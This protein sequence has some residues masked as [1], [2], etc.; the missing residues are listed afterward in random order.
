[1]KLTL[2]IKILIIALV[3]LLCILLLAYSVIGIIFLGPSKDASRMLVSTLMETSAAK[4]V[5]RLYMSKA[6][7]NAIISSTEKVVDNIEIDAS[8]IKLPG[9][10]ATEAEI[11]NS[12]TP[13]VSSPAED[14]TTAPEQNEVL[15]Q[16]PINDSGIEIH[17]I[18]SSNY[19][20]KMMIIKDPTRVFVGVPEAGFGEGKK[21]MTVFEMVEHYGAVAGTNA[22]GFYDPNG[23]GSGGIPEGIV[24]CNGEILWDDGKAASIA[25]IDE[26]GILYVG[27]M[28]AK[29]AINKGIKYAASYGPALIMNGEPISQSARGYQPRTAIGQRADG[30]I[31][32]LVINGRSVSSLG[33]T[34]EDLIEIFIQY[35]AVNATNLDGGS[36][37]IMV[38]EGEYLTDS[39][40]IFGERVVP[41]SILIK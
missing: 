3:T 33:A 19:N 18:K 41:T 8:L 12:L 38:Y 17:D 9:T 39:A 27:Q 16:E 34:I 15:P 40:Y 5:P 25:G 32:L 23:S 24:I 36:S 26:K 10:E 1:M 30:A 6:R 22:G 31:L 2:P 37:S 14:G 13:E 28:T 20:G 4:F 11:D 21:G 7:I 35:E 29:A